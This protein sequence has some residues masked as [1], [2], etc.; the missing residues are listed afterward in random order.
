MIIVTGDTHGDFSRIHSRLFFF[1]R[2]VNNPDL[3][4]E[5]YKKVDYKE[6]DFLIICGD[7]GGVWKGVMDEAEE[8]SLY[9]LSRYNFTILFCDGNHENF[10]RLNSGEFEEMEWKGGRVHKITDNIYHLMRGYVFT[11]NST[12]FFV[13]GGAKSHDISDGIL[14]PEEYRSVEELKEN[15]EKLVKEG[16]KF[17]RVEG[18]SWWSEELPNSDEMRR[19]VE[20]L[21]KVG[22]KVDYIISHCLPQT[23]AHNLSQAFKGDLLMT[24]FDELLEKGLRFK[25]WYCGHYHIDRT[26]M[27]KFEVL[28]TSMTEVE[29]DE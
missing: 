15:I 4:W 14:Y 29:G 8:F 24:Y 20:E 17:F 21:D 7:F 1:E 22:W 5:E 28:F 9:L 3:T 27:G 23:V 26:V 16:K 2:R 19:G 11:I 6:E 10:T 13:F 12:S 25:K 18:V